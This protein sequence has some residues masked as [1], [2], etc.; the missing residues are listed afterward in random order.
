MRFEAAGDSDARLIR[1]E[2]HADARGA[3]ARTWCVDEF[4]RAGITFQPVQANSSLTRDRGTIR[5]MHFQRAPGAEAK[6]VR[7]SRGRVWDVITDLRP[8]ARTFG[9]SFGFE[10]A[11]GYANALYVPAGFAHGF[12]TLTDEVT[13]EYLMDACYAPNLADGFRY[14]DP[15]AGIRWP[16]AAGGVS[17]KD[18]AWTTLQSRFPDLTAEGAARG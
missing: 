1:L 7:C 3:F 8:E 9:A 4:R 5:G 13:V 12:Q 2:P 15:A 17:A 14:D 18:L 6:L 16:L 10:L 11:D